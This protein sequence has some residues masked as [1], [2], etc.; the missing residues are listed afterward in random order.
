[1]NIRPQA[2][3]RMPYLAPCTQNFPTVKVLNRR[4]RYQQPNQTFKSAAISESVEEIKIIEGQ[5]DDLPVSASDSTGWKSLVGFCGL[6]GLICSVDRAA[7]SVAILPMSQEYGWDESTK[8][9]IS[10]V[11][12]LG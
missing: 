12:L 7:I 5:A 10:S 4:A 6:A 8:G 11:F 3:S 1:M 9:L 2:L